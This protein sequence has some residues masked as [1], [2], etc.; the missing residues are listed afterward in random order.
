MA[1]RRPFYGVLPD[2]YRGSY[3]VN[4]FG[5]INHKMEIVTGT[6]PPLNDEG[7]NDEFN[8]YQETP[9]YEKL[10]KGMSL[11]EFKFIYFWEYFHRLWAR[12][13]GIVFIVPFLLFY[14]KGM[15]S[16]N[17]L[18]DLGVVIFL[19]ALAACFGW[20]MVAS[21]LIDRPWVNAYK[22]SIHLL[23]G[24]AVFWHYCGLP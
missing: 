12:I 1:V 22:L 15:L 8:K 18:T 2:H 5:F 9:Q 19:A 6:L 17:M 3:P 24:I 14:T 13:M 10:N 16:R 7:W 20:I 21:G 4:W 23:L 11:S